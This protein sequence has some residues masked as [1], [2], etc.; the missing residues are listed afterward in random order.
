MLISY[1]NY[2]GN[3]LIFCLYSN[4]CN[5]FIIIGDGAND[6]SMIQSADVGVGLIG[7]E[8]M[9]AVMASDFALP[10]FRFLERLLLVH[11]HWCCK[12][13]A[14]YALYI[15][16]KNLVCKIVS[17][18]FL[19]FKLMCQIDIIYILSALQL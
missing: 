5:L 13:F 1:N 2:V 6:V 10:R 7:Q 19:F 8:G 12:R 9:Q 11:G 15:I 4:L 3:I 16:Y 18:L 14:G 17:R